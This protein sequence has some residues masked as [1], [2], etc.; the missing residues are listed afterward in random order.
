MRSVAFSF[1]FVTLFG[2]W[3][4]PMRWILLPASG[5]SRHKSPGLWKTPEHPR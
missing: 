2:A 1:I 4:T 5:S 3:L